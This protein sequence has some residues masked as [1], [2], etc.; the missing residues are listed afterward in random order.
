MAPAA[1]GL[2]LAAALTA[3]SAVSESNEPATPASTTGGAASTTTATPSAGT[4]PSTTASPGGPKPGSFTVPKS[5]CDLVDA[6][7]LERISGRSGLSLRNVSAACTVTD[8]FLP[9]GAVTLVIRA[10]DTGKSAQQELDDTVADSVYGK[11]KA[12]DIP[13]LG[14]AA[15]YGTSPSL[16]GVT[17]ASIYVVDLRGTQV[18]SLSI[19]IDA[20]DPSTA[21][22]PLVALARTALG[23]I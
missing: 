8:G 22:D 17:F 3:C 15:R 14:A 18:A 4:S 19:S 12:E 5:T 16:G 6:A 1:L 21:K 13:G 23:K 7:S 11:D 2:F 10:A 20:K 9:V